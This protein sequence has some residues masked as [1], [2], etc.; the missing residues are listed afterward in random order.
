M[1]AVRNA[2]VMHNS[3]YVGQ[4]KAGHDLLHKPGLTEAMYILFTGNC[5][6]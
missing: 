4:V 5:K 3:E 1:V 2:V 6:Y